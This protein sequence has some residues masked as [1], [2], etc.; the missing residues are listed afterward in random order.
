MRVSVNIFVLLLPA[1]SLSDGLDMEPDIHEGLVVQDFPAVEDER[2]L[3]HRVVDPFVVVTLEIL[4][5]A[6]VFFRSTLLA[7]I[8]LRLF[9]TCKM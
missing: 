1:E 5:D 2:R 8:L 7:G 4:K 6:F 9:R 3:G